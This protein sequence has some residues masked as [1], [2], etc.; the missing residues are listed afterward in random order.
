M[1]DLENRPLIQKADQ[2]TP[3]A[4]SPAVH[5]IRVYNTLSRQKEVFETVTPGK[6][7]IYLCGPTVYSKSH[8]GHM[9]GPVIFD[10]VK[11]YLTYNGYHVQFVINITDVDD[12]IIHQAAKEGTSIDELSQ[13]ITADYQK[14]LASLAVEVDHFP[15]ATQYILSMQKMIHNLIRRGHAYA[16]GGDV[17]FDV[18]TYSDYGK[19]SNRRIEELLAGTR[20]EVSDLKRNSADF[21]LWKGAKPGEPSWPSPWGPGRPGWHIECS[22]MSSELL[23][24]TFDIHGGGLDLV[25]PHHEDEIAQSECSHGKLY[26]KYWMHNG[27]MQYSTET[28]KIGARENDF[29]SQE[30]SKMSKSKGNVRTLDDLFAK[31]KPA[32]VRY[33]LLSTHYRSPINF[34]DERIQEVGS[35]LTR[36][37]TLAEVVGRVLGETF[38]SIVAPNRRGELP[39]Q[40]GDDVF[41]AEVAERRRRFLEYMDDD[42]NTGGA[43]A[44]L[45]ELVGAINRLIGTDRL[46]DSDAD[47]SAK[48]RLRRAVV[49]VK[50]LAGILGLAIATPASAVAD[51][52]LMNK[53]LSLLVDLR[54]E[55]RQT[56]NFALSDRIRDG[57]AAIGIVLQDGREG[58]R[59]K[60]EAP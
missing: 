27:L 9:V 15:L 8:I 53:V 47:P 38:E 13:R 34:G 24:E 55:A 51:D 49:V 54:Q 22:V 1:G 52:E 31:F 3:M 36:L 33:F 19:L 59:W 2:P 7:G 57:L 42:F 50:E 26:A 17:Y 56:K 14:H 40:A 25:F 5:A 30:A 32:L 18:T 21:A 41:L 28:R 45:G 4:G 48:G 46:E 60:I 44:V 16:V 11:R 20:K 58:T 10:T 6:V 29:A 35:G 23:G 37:E 43:L 12:K 39:W